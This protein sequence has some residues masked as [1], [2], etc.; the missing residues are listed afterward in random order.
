VIRLL[1]CDDSTEA[2]RL[3]QTLFAGHPEIEVVGEAADGHDAVAAARELEPDVVLMDYGLPGLDG[4]EA[5][6]Q[7]RERRPETRVVA[8]TGLDDAAVIQSMLDAGASSVCVKGAPLWE[9]ERAIAGAS[10]PLLRLAHTLARP[11]TERALMSVVASETV[12][13]T[14]AVVVG[15]YIS[16]TIGIAPAAIAGPPG[17]ALSDRGG[18]EI[19]E[20]VRRA[21]SQSEAVWAGGRELID[22]YRIFDVATGAALALPLLANGDNLGVLLAVMPANVQFELDVE[23]VRAVADIASG[24]LGARRKLALSDEE[25][26]RDALTGLGN[27]RAFDEHLDRA[28]ERADASGEPLALILL[29][30][31]DFKQVNDTYGHAEGD[32]ALTALARILIGQ[33]R[34]DED[35]Y[36]IGGDELAI[37]LHGDADDAKVAATRFR[38]AV[39]EQ[40]RIESLTT[41]SVGIAAFPVHGAT[42]DDLV[43]CADAALYTAKADGKDRIVIYER[44]HERPRPVP[45]QAVPAP[46]EFEAPDSDRQTLRLLVVDD[47]PNL[48]M[49]LRTTFEIVDVDVDEAGT[50]AEAERRIDARRPDVIVLDVAL[51]D[52]DGITFCK[53][54]KDDPKTADI[55]VVLLTGTDAAE[56]VAEADAFIRKPFSPL[57]LL[58]TIER[59]AGRLPD[60]PYRLM[61]DERPD[62]QLLLYAQDLRRLLEVE[63]VQRSLIQSAYEETVTALARALESKDVGPGAHSER[64]RRY[65]LQLAE[66]HDP[67]L[68]EDPGLEW[69][70]LLHDIGKIGIPDGLLQKRGPLTDAERGVIQTHTV[71]GQQILSEVPLLQGQG[72]AVIRSHHERWDGTGYPDR[73]RADEIPIGARILAV[74]DSLDAMTT[75]RPYRKAGPWAAA[76]NEI[77]AQ[78]GHQFDPSI[79]ATFSSCEGEL[80]HIYEALGAA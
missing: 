33:T 1:I 2:R 36:R 22:I 37:L 43:R 18:S 77:T 48:R 17:V 30:L 58:E 71:L 27:R 51:P 70:F 28:L 57:D 32:R 78:A 39:L 61:V 54:L 38:S 6:R 52:A 69:G 44:E 47:Q 29:D 24:A 76:V 73:L 55:P 56:D 21:H 34:P 31:D 42:K 13:L 19:P 20:V 10:Q 41:L 62:E 11:I 14:G 5:T 35:V 68:L 12:D 3:L 64:V 16:G 49:L 80:W 23:L 26:R 46:P 15:T 75:N 50:A 74:A 60:G 9:L 59:L 67:Q 7:I 45:L 53:K 72:L 25:A 65:S 8:F 4:A 66:L 40:R 79:C 63:R